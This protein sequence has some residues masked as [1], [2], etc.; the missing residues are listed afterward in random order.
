M[1]CFESLEPFTSSGWL[2][3]GTLSLPLSSLKNLFKKPKSLAWMESSVRDSGG[4]G[5]NGPVAG[6]VC[7]L[8]SVLPGVLSGACPGAAA[9]GSTPCSLGSLFSGAVLGMTSNLPDAAD[10]SV[11]W[12]PGRPGTGRESVKKKWDLA[13]GALVLASFPRFFPLASPTAWASIVL[14]E[15]VATLSFKLLIPKSTVNTNINSGSFNKP[16]NSRVNNGLQLLI[17][18][19]SSA[20]WGALVPCSQRSRH[21]LTLL[22]PEERPSEAD[23]AEKPRTGKSLPARHHVSDTQCLLSSTTLGSREVYT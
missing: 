7:C 22:F 2:S 11:P 1:A 9:T 8:A 19:V 15:E 23:E 20:D 21:L 6:R 12:S 13:A 3:T 16:G 14:G 10:E 5:A 17:H 4:E 18:N